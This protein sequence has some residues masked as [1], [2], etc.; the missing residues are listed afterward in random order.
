MFCIHSLFNRRWKC[1]YP[2]LA[3][4]AVHHPSPCPPNHNDS[5]NNH[6][7]FSTTCTTPSRS[8]STHTRNASLG[9]INKCLR[10]SRVLF[11]REMAL[12]TTTAPSHNSSCPG[13]GRSCRFPGRRRG[14]AML[15]CSTSCRRRT[16]ARLRPA[17]Q[18]N[19]PKGRQR[20][21][22]HASG[23]F[24]SVAFPAASHPF[25]DDRSTSADTNHIFA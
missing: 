21:S 2:F 6:L 3:M 22:I 4:R 8:L 19:R 13:Y 14:C 1:L 23:P 10:L 16:R 24:L 17:F 9:K 18:D 5:I 25:R 15:F 20:P 11:Q 7:P 12:Y